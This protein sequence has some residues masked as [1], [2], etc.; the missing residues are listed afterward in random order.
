[1][2]EIGGYGEN[3]FITDFYDSVLPYVFRAD[4]N[5]YVNQTLRKGGSVLEPGSGRVESQYRW[6]VLV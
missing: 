2:D 5:Y 6:R 3:S 1:M 4:V